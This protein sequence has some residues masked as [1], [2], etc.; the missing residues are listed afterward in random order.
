MSRSYRKTKI[1]GHTGNSDKKGKRHA[2]RIFR[3]L[4]RVLLRFGLFYELPKKTK[5]LVSCW[6]F[7][8]DGKEYWHAATKKDMRK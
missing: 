5:E 2:N 7:P 1:F 8:K 6:S 4:E 3:R